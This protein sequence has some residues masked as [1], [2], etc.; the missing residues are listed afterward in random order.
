LNTLTEQN[1]LE[2]NLTPSVPSSSS[3]EENPNDFDDQFYTVTSLDKTKFLDYINEAKNNAKNLETPPLSTIV[4]DTSSNRAD[5]IV[6]NS[7]PIKTSPSPSAYKENINSKHNSNHSSNASLNSSNNSMNDSSKLSRNPS[8]AYLKKLISEN[9]PNATK[10][11]NNNDDSLSPSPSKAA[12]NKES[13]ITS[14]TSSL[15]GFSTSFL[16]S[17]EPELK[18]YSGSSVSSHDDQND[19]IDLNQFSASSPVKS[20]KETQENYDKKSTITT[21]PA[22]SNGV[23]SSADSSLPRNSSLSPQSNYFYDEPGKTSN[24]L[25]RTTP[26]SAS[27]KK[28]PQNNTNN[29]QT[30]IISSNNTTNNNID[31]E[32]RKPWYSVSNKKIILFTNNFNLK[33]SSLINFLI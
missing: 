26:T 18:E 17:N 27:S 5:A 11:N 10:N 15:I 24:S 14:N 16:N 29:S 12:N 4:D 13:G 33:K 25:L 20:A 32:K 7:I 8:S 6:S 9:S 2:E 28:S 3:A 30:K 23:V 31:K 1:K 21:P 22:P 19:S